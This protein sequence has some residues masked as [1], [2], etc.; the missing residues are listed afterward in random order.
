MSETETYI[1]MLSGLPPHIA[2]GIHS[3]TKTEIVVMCDHF[4]AVIAK[5]I[6]H[7]PKEDLPDL[8]AQTKL[9]DEIEGL[10]IAELERRTKITTTNQ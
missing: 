4:R 2:Q 10:L 3:L 7:I 8:Q 1:P 6:R 5:R 9:I